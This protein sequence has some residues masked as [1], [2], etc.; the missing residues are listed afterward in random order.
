[1]KKKIS[2]L[3]IAAALSTAFCFCAC[4]G[5]DTAA[6]VATQIE[7]ASAA[8]DNAD[9]D[10]SVAATTEDRSPDVPVGSPTDALPQPG[11][12]FM[13]KKIGSTKIVPNQDDHNHGI[14]YYY[15]EDGNEI[16]YSKY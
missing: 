12:T 11:E 4:N 2:L 10:K 1:M 7:K 13:G 3:V 6:A 15:D 5:D 8:V 16:C 14:I 9:A